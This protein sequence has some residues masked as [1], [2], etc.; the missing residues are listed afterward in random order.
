M[1]LIKDKED[2]YV[3]C[4]RRRHRTASHPLPRTATGEAKSILMMAKA[5]V[6]PQKPLTISRMELTAT[7]FAVKRN[8]LLKKELELEL[9]D[10]TFLG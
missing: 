3:N 6:V 4:M 7:T 2:V 1:K 10:L 5:R 9:Q 8:K